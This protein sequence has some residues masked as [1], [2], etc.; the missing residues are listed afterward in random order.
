MWLT[1]CGFDFFLHTPGIAW[2]L[3]SQAGLSSPLSFSLR[4]S[5]ISSHSS[6][7]IWVS[8]AQCRLN[9]LNLFILAA[10]KPDSSTH[11]P[12]V[13]QLEFFRLKWRVGLVYSAK[14]HLVRFDH[15]SSPVKTWIQVLPSIVITTFPCFLSPANMVNKQVS[16]KCQMK[17]TLWQAIRDLFPN[18][19]HACPCT[20]PVPSL[21]L[22][23]IPAFTV[24]SQ[25]RVLRG[26]LTYF[27]TGRPCLHQLIP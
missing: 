3:Q 6:V 1:W 14:F 22:C 11:Y 24:Q 27:Q 26:A 12:E 19:F 7:I 15:C 20:L 21:C 17:R 23:A 5:Y 4:Y 13:M 10:A 18:S 25:A 8:L 16:D 2:P 9:P